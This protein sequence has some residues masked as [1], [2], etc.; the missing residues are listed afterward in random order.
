MPH[1]LYYLIVVFFAYHYTFLLKLKNAITRTFAGMKIIHILIF[2]KINMDFHHQ[3]GFQYLNVY[4]SEYYLVSG[5]NIPTILF[6]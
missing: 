4:R 6:Y 1:M 2:M 5:I 3:K